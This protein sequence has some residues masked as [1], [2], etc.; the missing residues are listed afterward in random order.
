M[1]KMIVCGHSFGGMTMIE[2]SRLE[3]QKIKACLTHDPWLYCREKEINGGGFSLE[4]PF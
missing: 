2:V 1:T 3:P 4:V